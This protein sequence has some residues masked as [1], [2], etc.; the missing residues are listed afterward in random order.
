MLDEPPRGAVDGGVDPVDSHALA[1]G[2]RQ[3]G[4]RPRQSVCHSAVVVTVRVGLAHRPC[5]QAG[6]GVPATRLVL[7]AQQPG[8]RPEYQPQGRVGVRISLPRKEIHAHASQA[9]DEVEG[10]GPAPLEGV[11]P[12]RRTAGTGQQHAVERGQQARVALA[13]GGQV[14]GGVPDACQPSEQ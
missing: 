12:V 4:E 5:H 3:Q 6:R 14:D 10:A 2:D 1:G 8:Q 9:G 13:A 11:Q 7:V